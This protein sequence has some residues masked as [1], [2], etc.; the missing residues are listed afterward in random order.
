MPLLVT[1]GKEVAT[2]SDEVLARLIPLVAVPGDVLGAEPDLP[3]R[4]QV[5][6]LGALLGYYR[7]RQQNFNLIITN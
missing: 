5:D 7:L 3:P 1:I 6:V 2:G 4:G